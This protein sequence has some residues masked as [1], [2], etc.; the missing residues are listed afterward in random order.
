MGRDPADSAR[1]RTKLMPA[2]YFGDRGVR[3]A[4]FLEDLQLFFPAGR[5][6]V[7]RVLLIVLSRSPVTRGSRETVSLHR[8]SLKVDFR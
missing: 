1:G 2:Q 8:S 5:R 4:R 3:L 7:L 6:C